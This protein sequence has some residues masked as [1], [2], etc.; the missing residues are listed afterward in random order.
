MKNKYGYSIEALY[1]GYT[2][3]TN[4]RGD[5]EFR[6]NIYSPLDS[7]P[8]ALRSKAI[9]KDWRLYRC[10]T[11]H[12]VTHAIHTKPTKN[13]SRPIAIVTNFNVPC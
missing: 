4:I 13:R 9:R 8:A 12:F 5:F 2:Q 7:I 6:S 1:W 10:R 11:C 3:T